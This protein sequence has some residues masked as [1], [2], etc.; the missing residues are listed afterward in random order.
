MA[1]ESKYIQNYLSGESIDWNDGNATGI[2]NQVCASNSKSG[3]YGVYNFQGSLFNIPTGATILGIE[4]TTRRAVGDNNDVYL[5]ALHDGTDWRGKTGTNPSTTTCATAVDETLGTP[6]DTWGGS[7]TVSHI[8]SANFKIRIT[9]DA[10]AKAD[11]LY[12]DS[13]HVTVHYQSVT[14]HTK[15]FTVDA[16]LVGRFTKDFGADSV[17][18]ETQEKTFTIDAPLKKRSTKAFTSDAPLAARLERTFQGDSVLI[19][20]A[21]K[22]FT[23]DGYLKKTQE[24][25]FTGDSYLK[26]TFKKEFTADGSLQKRGFKSIDSDAVLKKTDI[27][28]TFTGDAT[29]VTRLTKPISSDSTIVDRLTRDF[30]SDTILVERPEKTFTADAYLQSSAETQT[31]EFTGDGVLKGT[32]TKTFSTDAF[33]EQTAEKTFTADS[34]LVEQHEETFT[35]DGILQKLGVDPLLK[36]DAVLSGEIT[37]VSQPSRGFP[38]P[39]WVKSPPRR[40][41]FKDYVILVAT[42]KKSFKESL[43]AKWTVRRVFSEAMVFKSKIIKKL[44]E[45]IHVEKT[46][47]DPILQ[48]YEEIEKLRNRITQLEKNS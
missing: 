20:R 34:L 27:P 17:L 26:E 12:V 19:T 8:N 30:S 1:S 5:L 38:S 45:K 15:T 14:Q 46:I 23:G 31:K 22:T 2:P 13:V 25:T 36:V 6:S 37:T 43:T 42:I 48:L 18:K 3:G 28:K 41:E 29:A 10:V 9:H 16:P 24:K 32:T 40:I 33:L 39:I 4:A 47:K 35:A 7:W 44:Y 21:E 11:T